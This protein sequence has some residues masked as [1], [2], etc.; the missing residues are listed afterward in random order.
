MAGNF[1]DLLIK[2]M[3]EAERRLFRCDDCALVATEGL[4]ARQPQPEG[5]AVPRSVM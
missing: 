2:A 5:V 1:N 3:R 4:D